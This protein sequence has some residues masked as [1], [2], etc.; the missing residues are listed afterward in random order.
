MFSEID[1]HNYMKRHLLKGS[2][3]SPRTYVMTA[4][5]EGLICVSFNFMGVEVDEIH[6]INAESDPGECFDFEF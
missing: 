3:V 5:P 1:K 4:A 2:Y 6:N